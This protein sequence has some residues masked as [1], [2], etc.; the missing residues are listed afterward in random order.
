MTCTKN[1]RDCIYGVPQA[2]MRCRNPNST[3]DG[4]CYKCSYRSEVSVRYFCTMHSTV[5][6]IMERKNGK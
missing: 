1:C 4:M 2:K 5:F 6:E 3:C